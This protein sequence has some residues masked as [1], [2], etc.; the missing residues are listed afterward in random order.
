[1][2]EKPIEQKM[3]KHNFATMNRSQYYSITDVVKTF[4]ISRFKLQKLID[5]KTLQP[6][7]KQVDLGLYQVTA[8][9]FDKASVDNLKLEKR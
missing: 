7:V 5:N 1:M 4:K 9:Y 8:Q 2:Y 6:E 3:K